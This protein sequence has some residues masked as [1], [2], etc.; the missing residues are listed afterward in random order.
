MLRKAGINGFS[1]TKEFRKNQLLNKNIAYHN[2]IN[3]HNQ[4]KN[5]LQK[6]YNNTRGNIYN[7]YNIE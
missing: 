5:S 1:S 4:V 7:T 6:K 2:N 3:N